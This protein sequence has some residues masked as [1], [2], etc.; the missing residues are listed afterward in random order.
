MIVARFVLVLALVVA[1]AAGA[2]TAQSPARMVIATGV[3]P[4]F[5][6]F[7]V[8][9]EA[10]LFKKNGLDVQINTGPSGPFFLKRPASWAT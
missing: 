8:A 1:M 3:D 2:A 5:S 9:Q 4:A 10:G 6:Q 7:Y